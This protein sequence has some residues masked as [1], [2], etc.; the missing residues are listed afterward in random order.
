M[1]NLLQWSYGGSPCTVLVGEETSETSA[2]ASISDVG[3][4]SSSSGRQ[5]PSQTPS[6]SSGGIYSFGP[7]AHLRKRRSVDPPHDLPL[8]LV[9]VEV[10]EPTVETLTEHVPS[11]GSEALHS[12]VVSTDNTNSSAPPPGE[13]STILASTTPDD[14]TNNSTTT[15]TSTN[16]S[17]NTPSTVAK[18]VDSHEGNGQTRNYYKQNTIRRW[19]RDMIM[20]GHMSESVVLND[21]DANKKTVE[22]KASYSSTSVPLGGVLSFIN[23]TLVTNQ[24]EKKTLIPEVKFENNTYDIQSDFPAPPSVHAWRNT[25]Q[26]RKVETVLHPLTVKKIKHNNKEEKQNYFVGSVVK[27][28]NYPRT[29][30]VES[31]VDTGADEIEIYKLESFEDEVQEALDEEE[32]RRKKEKDSKHTTLTTQDKT[33]LENNIND[34]QT[35]NTTKGNDINLESTSTPP[36]LET[37]TYA[38]NPNIISLT[39]PNDT[40]HGSANRLFVNVTIATGDAASQTNMSA[41][42]PVYVLSL[43][44]PTG[45]SS[46]DIK[47]HPVVPQLENKAEVSPKTDIPETTTLITGFIN[48]GGECQC[49]C[50]CLSNLKLDETLSDVDMFPGPSSKSEE[51]VPTTLSLNISD[52]NSTT[53]MFI[54]TT[55]EYNETDNSEYIDGYETD[56]LENSTDPS[57]TGNLTENSTP[58]NTIEDI[59][60]IDVNTNETSVGTEEEDSTE[61]TMIPTTSE[62]TILDEDTDEYEDPE[63]TTS[64]KIPLECPKVTPQPPTVLILEGKVQIL[65]YKLILRVKTNLVQQLC[66]ISNTTYKA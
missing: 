5:R 65:I 14:I 17:T 41:L 39:L 13:Q 15:L 36:K 16:I 44:F 6:Q 7:V 32:T 37:S 28:E 47:I 9:D 25:Q 63:M 35:I 23:Q 61:M 11:D 38:P 20:A 21:L 49:S 3:N 57:T 33:W 52:E 54:E 4:R 42:N 62:D 60:V 58:Y 66:L 18:V 45:N 46:E 1:A 55:E 53:D 40:L 50:P 27:Y 24:K 59:S 48:R 56:Y 51:L 26:M 30:I 2:K 64:T 12:P 19:M 22:P 10:H 31:D 29:Q 43:S 34:S 8:S